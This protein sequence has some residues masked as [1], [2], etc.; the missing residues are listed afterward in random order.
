MSTHSQKRLSTSKSGNDVSLPWTPD[1]DLICEERFG[2]HI[3]DFIPEL[4]FEK[5]E[6]ISKARYI[7]H[8][9][10]CELFTEAFA[11]NCG[12]WCEKH[13][14]NMTG[15]MLQ[16]DSLGSQTGHNG[17]VMRAY[18]R[19][20]IPGIDMLCGA[21]NYTTAK[22]CQSAVHQYG[23]EVMMSELYGVTDWDFDFRGHKH[24][25]DWQAALG[26]TVR[27]PHLAW[28]S[29]YGESK[30]DYPASIFYQSPWYKEYPYIEN[31]FARLN[32]AHPR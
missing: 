21:H 24:H 10:V 32:T 6:G 17:E 30:R 11:D 1:F 22:Q 29:M 31:H 9:L 23:R 12:N 28:M 14:L 27:V 25:G 19:F 3:D 4:I 7:Y 2:I 13:G 5:K 16:E 8:E 18:R 26:V 20:H 15:H